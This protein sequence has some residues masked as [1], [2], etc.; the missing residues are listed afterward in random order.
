[1]RNGGEN[2][3]PGCVNLSFHCV[4]VR[5]GCK[6][7]Y[8]VKWD[9]LHVQF[10][11]GEKLCHSGREYVDGHE[12]CG[13]VLW[14]SLVGENSVHKFLPFNLDLCLYLFVLVARLLHW[15][16]VM[17]CARWVLRRTWLTAVS[18]VNT[19]FYCQKLISLCVRRHFTDLLRLSGLG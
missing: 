15:S 17:C 5:N 1:M 8:T 6:G 9:T 4:E 12:R 10:S 16:Q 2:V 18:G 19:F 14:F 11:L 3:Y 13:I 7:L